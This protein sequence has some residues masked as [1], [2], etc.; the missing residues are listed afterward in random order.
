M[1]I[2]SKIDTALGYLSTRISAGGLSAESSKNHLAAY[3]RLLA[4][5][6]R[7]DSKYDDSMMAMI[8]WKFD[9]FTPYI[10]WTNNGQPGDFTSQAGREF[11]LDLFTSGLFNI[12]VASKGITNT[13]ALNNCGY[14]SFELVTHSTEPTTVPVYNNHSYDFISSSGNTNYLSFPRKYL[15]VIPIKNTSLSA[16]VTVNPEMFLTAYNTY[17]PGGMYAYIPNGDNSNRAGITDCS[18]STDFQQ[19]VTSSR[20]G[21]VATTGFTI[22][23]NTSAFLVFVASAQYATSVTHHY[24]FSIDMCFYN[25][26]ENI[27]RSTIEVDYGLLHTLW[28]KKATSF[29]NAINITPAGFSPKPPLFTV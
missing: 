10:G 8:R 29:L 18:L 15:C 13:T 3:N 28:T 19:S 11:Y 25:I 21:L 14:H 23:A 22:P 1:D 24:Y 6:Q 2:K 12:N 5:S 4:L 17:S 20:T 26:K 9:H 27:F 16:S 7:T